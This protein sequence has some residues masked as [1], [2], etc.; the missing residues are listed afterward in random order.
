MDV[1]LIFSILT[2]IT[3]IVLHFG[4]DDLVRQCVERIPQYNQ[5]YPAAKPDVS[6]SIEEMI[7]K[8]FPP[9]RNIVWHKAT[10]SQKRSY[11]VMKPNGDDEVRVK[12]SNGGICSKAGM[13]QRFCL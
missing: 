4:L 11:W 10:H 1:P 3:I 8:G 9:N 12:I 13:C 7:N 6:A 2:V 5:V